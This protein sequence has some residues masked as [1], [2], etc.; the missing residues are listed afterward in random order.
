M[1]VLRQ[2]TPGKP[3]FLHSGA[4]RHTARLKDVSVDETESV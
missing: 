4:V 1:L 3:G 2:R